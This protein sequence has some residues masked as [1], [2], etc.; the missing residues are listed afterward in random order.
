MFPGHSISLQDLTTLPTLGLE[1]GFSYLSFPRVV[2]HRIC[3]ILVVF[4]K[5]SYKGRFEN[6][7]PDI[8]KNW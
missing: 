5:S 8:S 3:L 6:W 7:F 1:L 2:C 4:G